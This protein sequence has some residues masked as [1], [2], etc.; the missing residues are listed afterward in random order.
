MNTVNHVYSWGHNWLG[1]LGR[2]VT[3]KGVYL[4]PERISY[5][6]DKVV[7]QISCG[8]FHSLALTSSGQVYGW[9]SNCNGQIGCGD[10]QNNNFDDKETENVLKEVKNLEKVKSEYVVQYYHS[11]RETGCLYIQMEFCSHNLQN[12]LEV[13]PQVFGR[14]SGDP[15]N[16]Y[17]YFISCEIF[18]QILECVQYL[19]ELKPQIIH[20]DLK[21]DNI[22][23][24][25]NVTKGRFLKLCDF[26]LATVHD[27]R[28]HYRTT[29]RHTA[30]VGDLRYMAPEIGQ[31]PLY[32]HQAGMQ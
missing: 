21:P 18:R 14:Q 5:F 29:H 8:S 7:Q 20:R 1:Q 27:K 23:I 32:T 3:P 15:M 19:H 25:H 28:V 9:G 11:W 10:K 2:D 26:G 17:E 30:D 16:L 4:K 12:I 6:D 31:D 24:A 22:L 13:K